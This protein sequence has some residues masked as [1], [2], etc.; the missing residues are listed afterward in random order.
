MLFIL[1]R[2]RYPM[3]IKWITLLATHQARSSASW[4]TWL[5]TA[6][7]PSTFVWNRA[8]KQQRPRGLLHLSPRAWCSSRQSPRA[9]EAADRHK[10]ELWLQEA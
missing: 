1:C 5:G 9:G 2:S 10:T 3:V 7:S 4:Q 8:M 6:P